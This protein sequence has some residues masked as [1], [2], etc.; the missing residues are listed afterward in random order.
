[1]VD[2]CCDCRIFPSDELRLTLPLDFRI[3]EDLVTTHCNK[4][5]P[6]VTT[7]FTL[8]K[9]LSCVKISCPGTK[10]GKQRGWVVVIAIDFFCL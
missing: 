8:K 7:T 3:K 6:R 2:G 9:H 4:V 5:Q 10:V 1:M